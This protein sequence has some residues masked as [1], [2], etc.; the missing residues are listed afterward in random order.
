[1]KLNRMYDELAYLW[2]LIS[3]VEDYAEEAAYWRQV[4]REKLGPGR[5]PILELGVGGGHNLS[6]LAGEFEATAVDLAE[7]MLAHSRRLNPGVAHYQG[8]MRTVRLGRKFKAVLIHDAISY[9]LTEDDL[10][11]TF[12]TAAAHLEPGGVFITAP[13]DYRETFVSPQVSSET[14]A[15]GGTELTY[16]EYHYDPDPADTTIETIYLYLIRENGGPVR[17]EQDRHVTGL[18]PLARWLEL[19]AAAGFDVERRPYD[20]YGDGREGFLLV[21]TLQ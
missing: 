6:H 15:V 19:M 12:A 2:P 4:L 7:G 14:H 9:M 11:Q 18:F 16:F 10:R 13:D 20:V 3:P 21:G 5:L 17:V 8:D 1:M